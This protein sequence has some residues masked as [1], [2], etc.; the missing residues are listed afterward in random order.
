MAAAMKAKLASMVEA[1]ESKEQWEELKSSLNTKLLVIDLHKKWCGPCTVMRPTL[2]RIYLDLDHQEDRIKF[3][4]MHEESG[5]DDEALK[6]LFEDDSCKPR[7]VC[8]LGGAIVGNIEGA[9]SPALTQCI[10]E[11]VPEFEE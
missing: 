9:L 5:V 4:S 7:F 10:M 1:V 6:A 8:M 11:N 3:V 2:E